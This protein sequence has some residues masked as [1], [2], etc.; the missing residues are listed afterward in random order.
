MTLETES[1]IIGALKCDYSCEQEEP[2]LDQKVYLQNLAVHGG[3]AVIAP[4]S[5]QQWPALFDEKFT[6]NADSVRPTC[7]S[8]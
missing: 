6:W 3:G 1:I 5:Q 7:G 4:V 8:E 2:L